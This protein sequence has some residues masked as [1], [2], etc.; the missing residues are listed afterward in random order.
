[1]LFLMAVLIVAISLWYTNQFVKKLSFEERQKAQLWAEAIQKKAS[2]VKYTQELFEKLK[3][4]EHSK[5]EIWAKAMHGLLVDD[6][7]KDLTLYIDIITSNKNIPIILTDNNDRVFSSKNLSFDLKNNAKLPLNVKEEFTKKYP[8]IKVSYKNQ[9][10]SLLYYKD[11]KLF[12]DLQNVM[13]DLIRTFISEVVINSASVPVIYT[14]STQKNII[15][16]GNVDSSKA[17]NKEYVLKILSAMS[18]QNKPIEV[19]LSNN[20]KNYIFYEDSYLLRQLRFYPFILFAIIGVFLLITYFLFNNVRKA[21]QNK[22][23][24]GM[25]KE[26]AHQLGTPLSSLIAWVEY[27]RLK[28]IDESIIVEI[29]KDVKQLEVITDRFSKIGSEPKL[30]SE[31]ISMVIHE[32]VDYMKP[33]ISDKIKFSINNPESDF[34]APMNIPLFQWVFEN[35]FKN[36][37]DA[38]SG[39]KGNIE[40]TLTGDNKNIFI[41]VSDTG[42]GIPKSKFK[43]IFKPG[44][45]SKNRGWGLGLSLSKRIIEDYHK[46]K[47]FVKQS[48]VCKGT[49]FRI[50]LKKS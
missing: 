29:S 25:A 24:V 15:A 8:P 48:I 20:T 49:T 5:V 40:I 27:L 41:D 17:K 34:F 12:S 19:H 10:L 43:T 46:G 32:C 3:D 37:V 50:I 36:A 23:W 44:Y 16:Y 7:S 2:L 31:N 14:D 11:S 39:E 28:E 38:M 26:T 35:L 33:R 30:T 18:S 47:I 42:K 13:N 1:M 21:E 45:T 4:D 9:N 6:N 22:V